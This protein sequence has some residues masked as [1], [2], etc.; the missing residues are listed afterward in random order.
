MGA[1]N[2][3]RQCIWNCLIKRQLQT[4]SATTINILITPEP[5]TAMWTLY[6]E[7]RQFMN[8]NRSG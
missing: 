1:Q 5:G 8:R 3:F 2:N 4:T 7:R 6:V